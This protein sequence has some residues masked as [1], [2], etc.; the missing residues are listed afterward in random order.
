MVLQL[1]TCAVCFNYIFCITLPCDQTYEARNG[2]LCYPC[3]PGYFQVSD[4]VV[5]GE[6]ARCRRCGNGE[7]QPYCDNSIKC[8]SCTLF[9]LPGQVIVKQC[10]ATN[11]KECQCKAGFFWKP[12]AAKPD[13]AEP[14]AVKPDEGHCKSHS[15]CGPGEGMVEIGTPYEDT[16]CEP[17]REGVFYSDNSSFDICTPCSTCNTT[18]IT[19]CTAIH[20]TVCGDQFPRRPPQTKKSSNRIGDS[21]IA[22]IVCSVILVV[23]LLVVAF[24]IYRYR[25]KKAFN[26]NTESC[27]F[28]LSETNTYRENGLENSH[29]LSQTNVVVSETETPEDIISANENDSSDESEEDSVMSY[30]NLQQ[31]REHGCGNNAFDS[32]SCTEFMTQNEPDNNFNA[33]QN[34]QATKCYQSPQTTGDCSEINKNLVNDNDLNQDL[35]VY[36]VQTNSTESG[37]E[38]LK[39]EDNEQ[40][41]VQGKNEYTE[42]G[43]KNTE[44][45]SLR[46]ANEK[47]LPAGP[48]KNIDSPLEGKITAGNETIKYDE[49]NINN[50]EHTDLSTDAAAV[51][52]RSSLQYEISHREG[53]TEESMT[54]E[55]KSEVGSQIGGD[56]EDDRLEETTRSD[57][58]SREDR[59]WFETNAFI[60][61]N[62]QWCDFRLFIMQ[63]VAN[64]KDELLKTIHVIIEHA[65]EENK[66][67]RNRI[68]SVMNTWRQAAP[69]A[70]VQCIFKALKEC[71]QELTRKEL[72]EALIQ[73]GL[74]D[75]M[76][77]P[78]H[79]MVGQNEETAQ[80]NYLSPGEG[81][82]HIH[83]EIKH[84]MN[85]LKV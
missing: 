72:K 56:F 16:K 14:G 64:T 85:E 80:K 36:D 68:Y 6:Q 19:K 20:D 66:Y 74:L 53:I 73:K 12:D 2:H 83:S 62:M 24:F 69:K 34:A 17:C 41:Q 61:R 3:S 4:C 45:N 52:P 22:G 7:Y 42:Y 32:Q 78:F 60:S 44:S 15:K 55:N 28:D 38:N 43:S 47:T 75:R 54:E 82:A 13:E 39:E 65:Q 11:N 1:L 63:L 26:R 50:G 49:S 5:D 9:C 67:C 21:A 33:I 29:S 79:Y 84:E 46:S 51:L 8:A 81:S 25:R 71:S 57:D 18:V 30:A 48:V 76:N 35:M 59:M 31:S 23:V 40:I 70:T 27:N 77:S 10:N 58:C 37:D